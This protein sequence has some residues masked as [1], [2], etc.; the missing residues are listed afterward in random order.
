MRLILVRHGESP[1]NVT[2]SI[3][4]RVPGPPLTELGVEQAAALP[5]ALRAEPVDVIYASTM[6]RAQM[7]AEPL[8]GV[9]GL[10]VLVRDGLREVTAGDLEM[11]NDDAAVDLYLETVFAWPAGD[12]ER[13]MPGGENGFEAFARFDEVVAEAAKTTSGTACLVSHGGV[14]R[15]WVAGRSDNVDA[16]Y[17]AATPLL[18][19]AAIIVD[20]SVESGWHVESWTG[21][22]VGG[23]PMSE[24][25]GPGGEAL[26]G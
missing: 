5:E 13:R 10:P 2:R 20:G 1:S 16:A 24:G 9:R 6:R 26:T 18:N 23:V 14:I 4:T 17:V 19:T 12:L 11:R 8:A 7:T 25:E 3:D 22:I 15:M 21:Y